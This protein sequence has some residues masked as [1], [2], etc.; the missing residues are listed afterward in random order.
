MLFNF[1]FLSV[2]RCMFMLDYIIICMMMIMIMTISKRL[3]ND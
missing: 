3:A 2:A 1:L